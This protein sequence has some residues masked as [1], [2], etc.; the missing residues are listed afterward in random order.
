[1]THYIYIV[2]TRTNKHKQTDAL[3]YVNDCC[4][5][6]NC[7]SIKC[8]KQQEKYLCFRAKKS[9]LVASTK[10]GSDRIGPDWITDRIT[11]RITEKKVLKKKKSKKNQFVYELVINKKEKWKTK[12][13]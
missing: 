1:M 6:N 2:K 12:V 4:G 3:H 11:D 8:D 13:C 9:N 7:Y 10:S 5:L